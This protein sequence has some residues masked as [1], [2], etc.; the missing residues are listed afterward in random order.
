MVQGIGRRALTADELVLLGY[1]A[2]EAEALAP[3]LRPI[4]DSAT[5]EWFAKYSNRDY[6]A[7]SILSL[8]NDI[9]FTLA[10]ELATT[11]RGVLTL[12][13]LLD[14]V[15]AAGEQPLWQRPIADLAL[16][17]ARDDRFTDAD[18][19]AYVRAGIGRE[20]VGSF[21]P[22][23]PERRLSDEMLEFLAAMRSHDTR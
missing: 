15:T 10:E 3:Q 22:T 7:A 21:D 1:T 18:L 19:V 13:A 5:P 6:P 16:A 14:E 9:S 23:D 2:A 8:T 11:G 12:V 4:A 20:E 17:W